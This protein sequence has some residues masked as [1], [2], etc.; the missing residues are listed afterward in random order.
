M[1]HKTTS[2]SFNK[3]QKASTQSISM[4]PTCM[5]SKYTFKNERMEIFVLSYRS[6]TINN[7]QDKLAIGHRKCA[8]IVWAVTLLYPI[9]KEA[10]FTICTYHEAPHPNFTIAKATRKGHAGIRDHE[11]SGLTQTNAQDTAQKFW[12]AEAFKTKADN[13]HPFYRKSPSLPFAQKFL[14]SAPSAPKTGLEIFEKSK[15]QFIC[16]ISEVHTV[17]E[18]ADNEKRKVAPVSE[19][20]AAQSASKICHATVVSTQNWN[21]RVTVHRNGMCVQA[22]H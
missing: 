10:R 8:D 21:T 14:E 17:T 12:C 4:L 7:I 15:G 5:S 16:F 9:S 6:R 19:Q 13:C 22:S 1:V 20:I 2:T 3:T 18:I 11:N